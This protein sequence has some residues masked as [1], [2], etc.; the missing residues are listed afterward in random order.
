MFCLIPPTVPHKP[1]G[2]PVAFLSIETLGHKLLRSCELLQVFSALLPTNR[3]K[4]K[5]AQSIP[6][7]C[8]TDQEGT[9]NTSHIS[10]CY[11]IPPTHGG[12]ASVASGS[13]RSNHMTTPSML[14]S[15][16]ISV[17]GG[18]CKLRFLF[19]KKLLLITK[20]NKQVT[21]KLGGPLQREE[22]AP[23]LWNQ[24]NT[25]AWNLGREKVSRDAHSDGWTSLAALKATT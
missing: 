3:R 23:I 2:H 10:T 17:I 14:S 25:G 5:I 12:L 8:C 15:T 24:G 1:P 21:L 9:G 18:L 4:R 16:R 13:Q 22:K 11:L 19:I 20:G 7:S 6:A